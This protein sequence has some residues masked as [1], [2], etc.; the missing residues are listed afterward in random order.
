MGNSRQA[1]PARLLRATLIAVL[2]TAV[3]VP[4][5]VA[6]QFGYTIPNQNFVWTWGKGE[7]HGTRQDFDARGGEAG[8]NCNLTGAMRVGHDLSPTERIAFE[9]QL[10]TSLQFIYDATTLMNQLDLQ[11]SL[12]WAQLDCKKY[13]AKPLTEEQKAE[14]ESRAR[15]KAQ[16]EVERR[17]AKRAHDAGN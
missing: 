12:E 5:V 6:A 9:Q 14:R 1:A 15:S 8:F 16:A 3:A 2:C 13:E 7:G 4:R 11:F 17:R 10:S